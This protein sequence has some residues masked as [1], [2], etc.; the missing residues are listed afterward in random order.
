MSPI[1]PLSPGRENLKTPEIKL[2][3]INITDSCTIIP[4]SEVRQQFE[5]LQ[6]TKSLIVV[7][8]EAAAMNE[9]TRKLSR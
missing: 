2:N 1:S 5:P 7:V 9:N 8:I 6:Q 4:I 3:K